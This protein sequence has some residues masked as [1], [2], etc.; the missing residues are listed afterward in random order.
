MIARKV[1]ALAS[2]GA[3]GI[4][5]AASP[6][7]SVLSLAFPYGDPFSI[8]EFRL[9]RLSTEEISKEIELAVADQEFRDAVELVEVG[10][11][12]GHTFDPG[13]VARTKEK[14]IDIAWR[15]SFGFADGFATGQVSS[16]SS[17]A[18]ALAADYLVVGDLRDLAVEGAK[19]VSGETYDKLTLGLSLVGVATLVP[20]TG[21]VDVGASAIKTANKAKKLSKPMAEAV[22][23]MATDLVDLPA[24]RR[25]LTQTSDPL[26]KMPSIAGMKDL[27]RSVDYSDIDRTDFANLGKIA[28]DLVPIDAVGVKRRFSEVL[29]PDT[30][31]EVIVLTSATAAVASKGGMKATFRALE[32]SDT[33]ADLAKFAKLAE[34]TGD[35]SSSIFRLLGKGAVHLGDLV[36]AVIAALI[37]AVAW[38]VGAIWSLFAFVFNFRVLV[39]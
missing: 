37:A 2:L 29:R 27:V 3:S 28:T 30:L 17:I 21:P 10:Q 39:R 38:L 4:A 1:L 9:K 6:L 26:F 36:Y 31:S 20:G 7:P 11:E 22:G 15:N 35:R 19:A 16:P 32:S 33:P 8:T 34:K 23:K 12:Y 14:P 18:G 13:L 25:A 5:F 24:L